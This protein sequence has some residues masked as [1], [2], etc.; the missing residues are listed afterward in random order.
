ML[1]SM[2]CPHCKNRVLQKS[3]TQTRLRTDGPITFGLDGKARARCYWCKAEI[4]LP[5]QLTSEGDLPGEP[6][7][8]FLLGR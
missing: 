3:E 2:K 6:R 1:M 4:E 5:M 7:E 8:R